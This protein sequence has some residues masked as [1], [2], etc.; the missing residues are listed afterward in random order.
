MVTHQQADDSRD[1]SIRIGAKH[2]QYL[3]VLNK[4][5]NKR[6]TARPDPVRL[7]ASTEHVLTAVQEAVNDQQRLVV[8]SGGGE[9]SCWG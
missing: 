5:F 3:A 1:E 2:P 8:T 7:A 4:R 9:R 6:F